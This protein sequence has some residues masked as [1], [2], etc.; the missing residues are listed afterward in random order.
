LKSCIYIFLVPPRVTIPDS[1]TVVIV[2]EKVLLSCSVGGDPQP[3]IYWTK[4]GRSVQLNNRI[5]QLSNGSLVIY[6]STVSMHKNV[7]IKFSAHDAFLE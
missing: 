4:N 1:D 7:D 5:Q 2:A 3:D 6:D